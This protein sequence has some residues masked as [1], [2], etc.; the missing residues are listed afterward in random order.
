MAS[1]DA[2]AS[3]QADGGILKSAPPRPE[4][5][6]AAY[7]GSGRGR[8]TWRVSLTAERLFFQVEETEECLAMDRAGF[9]G[10]TRVGVLSSSRVALMLRA[11][12]H[13]VVNLPRAALDH[14][15]TWLGPERLKQY[16]AQVLR[17]G[18]TSTVLVGLLFLVPVGPEGWFRYLGAAAGLLLVIA[19]ALSRFAPTRAA[20]LLRAAGW[21]VLAAA[22]VLD[23]AEGGRTRW[24]LILVGILVY[25]VARYLRW[26]GFFAGR[27][28]E[29]AP[30]P[31][32]QDLGEDSLG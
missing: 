23:V 18:W 12:E 30:V 24:L 7:E 31:D 32:S 19:G 4:D 14:I 9:V 16:Q 8:E 29:P 22:F 20:F 17:A 2:F 10:S 5:V 26:Y 15:R 3:P 13:R 1:R 28:G 6:M 25:S 11:P 27:F 21:A